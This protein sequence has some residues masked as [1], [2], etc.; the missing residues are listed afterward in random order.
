VEDLDQRILTLLAADGRMSFTDLGK[1]TGLSTSAVHQRVKRLEQRGLITGLRRLDRLR[2]ARSPPDRVHLDPADRPVAARRLPRA[3]A[4]DQ[5]DRELLVGGRRRVLH[6]QGAGRRAHRPR[7]PARPR[8]LRGKRVHPYDDR[9]LDALREQAGEL[10]EVAGEPSPAGRVTQET[11]T[12]FDVANAV[13]D[14]LVPSPC[15]WVLLH[16]RTAVLEVAAAGASRP[17]REAGLGVP[18]AGEPL[19]IVTLRHRDPDLE[20]ALRGLVQALRPR[21]GDPYGSGRVTLTG[22]SR[23]ASQIDPA[24]LRAIATD[25]D[26]LA[27]LERLYL[28]SAV[29]TPVVADGLVLGALNLVRAAEDAAAPDVL[30]SDALSVAEDIGRRIG[31]ALDASGPA[32]ARQ[33]LPRDVAS[34]RWEPS[35]EAPNPVAEARRW[36]RRTLPELVRRTVRE[37]LPADLDLVVSELCGNALRHTGTIGE[38]ALEA[39]PDAVRVVVADPDDRDPHV[40]HPDRTVESGRGLMIVEALSSAWATEHDR[41]GTGKRVWADLRLSVR[42]RGVGDHPAAERLGGGRAVLRSAPSPDASATW[43]VRSSSCFIQRTKSPAARSVS[44]STSSSGAPSAQRYAAH[45]KP[46]SGS[47]R[48][49]RWCSRSRRRG[50]PTATPCPRAPP[51]AA[52]RAAGERPRRRVAGSRTPAPTG[53]PPARRPTAVPQARA[54]RLGGDQV[55]VGVDPHQPGAV[56]VTSSFSR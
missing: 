8:P 38:V 6:P 29:I 16:V 9:A 17:I 15:D 4:G 53:Q 7:G 55:H 2:P 40:R 45:A 56:S 39:R 41:P 10:S 25:E 1:A 36:V 28:G 21:V 19:S 34:A 48:K 42:H 33:P 11:R 49:S 35:A 47:R 37:D 27:L 51:D 54:Q 26:N 46:R 44:V 31:R 13:G 43:S 52:T 30:G 18:R 22:R 23:L 32:V 50:R 20:V 14:R 12:W 5:R 3:A 24:H